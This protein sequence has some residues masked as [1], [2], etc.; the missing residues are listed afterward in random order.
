MQ[1]DRN[2]GLRD[3]VRTLLV[4]AIMLG[5]VIA[6]W[7]DAAG[8]SASAKA[9]PGALTVI[10]LLAIIAITVQTIRRATR[11]NAGDAPQPKPAGSHA[12]ARIAIVIAPALLVAVWD[13]LGAILALL[14]Y[15]GAIML[16]LRER[17]PLWLIGLPVGLS[18][19]L[20]YLFKTV[21]YLRLP[22]GFL[23]IG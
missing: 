13:H 17:R 18:L 1:E 14:L 5:G 3:T 4:P 11:A 2:P 23:G 7:I 9:F 20:V 10:I 16:L 8:V 15:T 19:A 21:L 22:D 6:Y 12:I